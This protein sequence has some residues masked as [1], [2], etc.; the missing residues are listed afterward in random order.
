MRYGFAS[1]RAVVDHNSEAS[2]QIQLF[3]D[4][5][6]CKEEVTKCGLVFGGSFAD[7]GDGLTGDDKNVSR[8]LWVDVVDGDAEIVFVFDVG[9]DFTV[10]DLLK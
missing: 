3:G 2:V 7:S 1:V 9:R 8:G 4:A 6:G 5:C 10:H